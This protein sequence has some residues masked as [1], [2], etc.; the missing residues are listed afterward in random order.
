MPLATLPARI[1]IHLSIRMK[2]RSLFPRFLAAALFLWAVGTTMAADPLRVFIR[3]GVKTHGPNQHDHPRFLGEWSKLLAERG[4][5]AGGGMKFPNADEL[6]STDVLIIYAAD[7]MNIQGDDR[8]HLETFLKR[9]GGLVVLH[10]GV[11]AGDQNEWAKSIIGGS[12]IWKDNKEGKKATEWHEGEV[13][14]YFVDQDHPITKG[15]SNFDWKDEVYDVMDMSADV[16]VLASSFIEVHNIWPQIWTYEKTLPGGTQPYRAFVSI[17]GHEYDVFNTPHYRAILLRGIAWAGKRA[18]V[19]EFCSKAELDSLRYPEG[20]PVPASKA[21]TKLNLHPEFNVTLTADENIAEKI[22]SIDWDPKGRLW[23]VETPEYP[24]GRDINKN[25]API[26]PEWALDPSKYPVGGKEPRKPKDRVSILEDTNGDGLMDKKTVWAEGLELPTSLV[27]YKDGVIVSQAPDIFWIRDTDGDGKADKTEVLYTGFGTFD[28]HAVINNLVWGLDGFVYGTVGYTRGKDVRSPKTGKRFGDISAGVYR[29]RPDGSLLE[30]VAAEGC[31]TWGVDVAPDGEIFFSTAT[32]GEPLNHV[33]IPETILAKGSVGGIKAYKNIIEENK[34]YPPYKETRQ[35]YVQID[36]VG[37]WT[38]AAG[39]TIYDGGA[40]PAKW[41]PENR[42]SFFMSEATMHLF[43]HEFLDENGVTYQGHKEEGRKETEFLTSNDYWFRPIHSR[44]GPDGALY[45]VDFYNQIA[46]H[47][48]TRGPNHGARNAATRPDRDH[49]FTRLYRVQHKE[50][51]KLPAYTLDASKPAE[52]VKMLEHP[53]GWVRDTANRLLSETRPA[54]VVPAMASLAKSSSSRYG[55]IEALYALNNQGQLDGATLQAGLNDRDAAVRK[56][57]ARL[58]GDEGAVGSAKSLQ[59]LLNDPNGRVRI[60]ALISLGELPATLE[61]ADAIVAAWPNLKDPYLESAAIGAASKDPILFV[62]AALASKQPETVG[63]FLPFLARLVANQDAD[64]GAKL[65]QLVAAQPASAGELKRQTIEGFAAASN[66][67][68]IPAW[69]PALADGLKA[70]LVDDRTAGAVLPLVTRWDTKGEL[71]AAIKPA[72]AKAEAQLG[73]KSLPDAARGQIAANLIGVWKMDATIVPAVSAML[74]GDAS[75][76]LKRRLIEVLGSESAATSALVG[77]L[78][79]L[80]GELVEP[81]FGQI[82]KRAAAV[83]ALLTALED[84]KIDLTVLGPARQHR[85]RTHPDMAI[86]KRATAIIETLK[87]PETKQKD[88]LIA[89]LM[90]EVVKPGN[91]ENGHKLFTA[92]CAVCHAFK[93]E[94]S[95][96]APNLTGMGT[97]GPADLLVH[98]VDPNRLVE[99][100]FISV[101]I[102]TKG[103]DIYDGIVDRENR[104]EIVIRNASGPVTI[105]KADIATRQS[106]GR[107]LMPEGFEQLGGD[108]LRDLLAY[109]CA[110]ENQFRVIDLGKAF[111]ANAS[112]GLFNNPEDKGESLNFVKYGLLTVDGVPFDVVSPKKVIANVVMLKGGPEG[113]IPR[114]QM[115]Q[116]VEFKVGLAASRLHFL[117]NSGPWAYPYANDKTLK[118]YQATL[119]FADGKTQDIVLRNGIEVAD[120]LGENDVPGSERQPELTERNKQVRT[121][122]RR[123][124]NTNVIESITLRSF[125]NIVSPMLFAITAE[126]PG[127]GNLKD[128]PPIAGSDAPA[129]PAAKFQWGPGIKVLIWGGGSSHDFNRF[130]NLADK[131][132]LEEGGFASVNYTEKQ[133]VAAANLDDADVLDF[134]TNI[135]INDPALREKVMNF[136]KSGK[137]IVFIHAGLWDNNKNWPEIHQRLIGGMTRGHDRYGE[138]EV[139]VTN[140]DHPVM[141]GVPTSYTTKDELYNHVLDTSVTPVEVLA[142]ATS[143]NTGKTFPQ[144]WVVKNPNARIVAITL[145]HDGIAHDGAPYKTLLRNAVKW[146]AHKD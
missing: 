32:C 111:T 106:S 44:V 23:V 115:P 80:P 88:D 135:A 31:N 134:N 78:A 2:L 76:D 5:K 99:P 127:H 72:V 52:L 81:A 61:I 25:D 133:D 98:I 91:V 43:H 124:D 84:K 103:G 114:K 51:I 66:A 139:K 30:Q 35:P 68:K 54:A 65:I 94:G 3:G 24:G 48:D 89:K 117:G 136:A 1:E 13:G 42:Y 59:A 20:G 119:H 7:G 118:A 130:F 140:P 131:R 67:A 50:A 132:T 145:G 128:E 95:D 36:W 96:L 122:A 63:S 37:A 101:A 27:F 34:I 126:L 100:N 92:N 123:V 22:M 15:V 85:L 6:A 45:V 12:W 26:N 49:H 64:A 21:V 73:N 121:L 86:A 77:V 62:E 116:Q 120:Y 11:V 10:D 69:S 146:T 18:N 142:T 33:I 40:W 104:N 90:P 8:S 112:Q 14:L 16:H 144:I 141:K 138:Y 29:F 57:A 19:D 4:M 55:R 83:N 137:G 38:A 143:P 9:G 70:L 47:N 113:S 110:D 79:Q 56:T 125:D 102:E 46:T 60:N 71:A 129:A 58:A 28:T 105:R 107:S 53:N 87:G 109:I 82:V 93:G 41:A 39:A 75:I 97:H 108:G 74:T 17:P